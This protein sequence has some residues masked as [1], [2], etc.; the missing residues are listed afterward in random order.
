MALGLMGC[1]T[2][3]PA[4]PVREVVRIPVPKPV[5]CTSQQL[6]SKALFSGSK[7]GVVVVEAEGSQGSGFVVRHQDGDTLLLTNSHVVGENRSVTLTWVDGRRDTATV[8]ADAG[9][10]SPQTDLALLRLEGI[11]GKA[12]EIRTD[13]PQVGADVVALGAPKGLEFSLTRGVV[14]SVRE[15]GEIIQLDAPINPGNSGGPVL[16]Q[17]GCVIGIATF[18][19]LESEGLNFAVGAGVIQGFL[20]RP[21][22]LADVAR[23]PP[24]PQEVAEADPPSTQPEQRSNC[25]FQLQEGNNNFTGFQCQVQ[26]RTNS[27]GHVVHDIVE[28][29]GGH[30]R[31]VVLWDNNTAE[32]FLDGEHYNGEWSTDS[33]GDVRVSVNGGVFIYTRP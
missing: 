19:L 30:R 4:P 16:D 3:A 9:G 11:R 14:S 7:D 25:W 32:V 27:N 24:P 17:T 29:N 23:D 15:G 8:V 5:P 28:P 12:L 18:K 13:P 1:K 33:D 20:I 21:T 10:S 2:R 31:S 26:G 6:D 22:P